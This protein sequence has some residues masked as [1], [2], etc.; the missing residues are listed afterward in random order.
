L[1]L[2]Q[3]EVVELVV[4]VLEQMLLLALVLLG[5]QILVAEV[6]AVD[7]QVVLVVLVAAVS[8]FLSIQNQFHHLQMQQTL[9]SLDPLALGLH[10]LE[11]PML[12]T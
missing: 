7:I 9:G 4:E 1:H 12:I 8:S 2:T 11:S 10:Q 6:A 5:Q 3:Q